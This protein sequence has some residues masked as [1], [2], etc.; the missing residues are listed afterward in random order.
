MNLYPSSDSASQPEAIQSITLSIVTPTLGQFSDHWLS[1]LLQVKGNIEFIHSYA[2]GNLPRPIEDPRV[3]AIFSPYKGEMM[4]RFVGLLNAKGKYILALDDDDY[5][6]PDICALCERYFH[7]F[8]ESWVL[9]LQTQKIDYLDCESIQKDWQKIPKL[10]D[11]T[12]VEKRNRDNPNSTLREIPIAPLDKAFDK[13]FLIWPLLERRDDR[14]PH[15]E[16]FNT[17]VWKNEL[18]QQTL[19]DIARATK[20]FGLLTWIPFCAFDR[21]MGLFLQAKFYQK[22]AIVG[23]WMPKPEQIRCIDKDPALKPPRYHV[24]SDILLVK[25]FPQYGY[26]WNLFFRKFYDIPRVVG[27]AIK[28]KVLKKSTPRAKV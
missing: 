16:N 24:A 22:D 17:K 2:P 19:P 27:K 21:F 15:I 4:Q 25:A 9:R 6:H 3:N 8:P 26:L 23:H 18:V 7:E 11:L 10:E 5:V 13:R 12:V 28:W 20:I 1:R 14:G